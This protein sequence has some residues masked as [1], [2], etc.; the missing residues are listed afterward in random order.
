M[1]AGN[2]EQA[3]REARRLHP[4]VV[5]MDIQ[6]PVLDGIEATRQLA[7]PGSPEPARVLI[8][9][10]FNLDEY[11]Y[12]ALH[13]GASG[14]LLKDAPPAELVAA[15]CTA[16]KQLSNVGGTLDNTLS[17]V[18]VLAFVI[19]GF[20]LAVAM[21]R[22]AGWTGLARFTRWVMVLVLALTVCDGVFSASAGGRFERLLALAGA[23]WIAVLAVAVTRR[24]VATRA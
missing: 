9:T 24:P 1:R 10:T 5:V 4:D 8:V 22:T 14:F 21:K 17:T 16:A 11:V 13:A 6:M 3:V 2:G 20:L 12:R 15:G 7:G 18:G 23:A 19:A